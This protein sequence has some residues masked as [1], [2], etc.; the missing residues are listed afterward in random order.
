MEEEKTP[1][2]GEQVETPVETPEETP[3]VEG[4]VEGTPSEEVP[5]GPSV[6]ELADKLEKME[7]R[8]QYLQRKLDSKEAKPVAPQEPKL[9]PRPTI[10]QFET[11]EQ[12]EDALFNWRDT[13]KAQEDARTRQQKEYDTSVAEFQRK[14][15][16]MRAKHSDF[17]DVIESPVF[18]P[19]MRMAILNSDK[20]P[21]LA[22]YLGRP[23]NRAVAENMQNLS[24]E[25]QLYEMGKLESKL[26]LAAKT[27]TRP[28]PPEPIEPVG[29]S[30]NVQ[31]K[32]PSKMTTDEWMAWDRQRMLERLQHKLKPI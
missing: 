31:E 21:E 32:D 15:E 19:G 14:A 25:R 13:I 2:E 12:Y 27:A 1:I 18:S 26:E 17:D 6:Q 5:A 16:T 10:D 11:T 24:P 23:E 7:R 20:G 30:G 9:P 4:E 28:D 22:Y 3:P 8:T 29:M